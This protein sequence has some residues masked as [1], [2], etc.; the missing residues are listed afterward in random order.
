M[1]FHLIYQQLSNNAQTPIRVVEQATGR[2]VGWINRYLD[3]EYVRRL[4]ET[5]LRIY[6]YH[7][8][9]FV[10]WWESVHHTGDIREGDLTES[11]LLDYVRFQSS[12]QPRPSPSTINDRVAVAD[13]AIRNKF[14]EAPCQI[15][16]G[17]HHAFL[18]RK[19]M[20]LGRPRVVLSRLRVKVPKRN[21][22]PLSV[23]EVARFWSSFR[24][25]RDLAIV[26]LMLLQG[27]RS[28]EVLALNQDDALLSE[29]QLRV[30][31][32]GNKFR[33][34]PLAPETVQ[35]LEH[36]LRLER[37]NPCSAALFVSLKGRAR[38]TRMT[39]AGLRSLF[40]HHRQTTNV[41]LANPHRFRHTFASD[42]IRAGMSLPALM[43]LMGHSDIQTTLI[44]VTVTPQ[45]VYQQYARAVAQHIRPLPVTT[46]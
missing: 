12:Q 38:G 43:Q 14:P 37:P 23:N 41:Q 17:F 34:L 26:G 31:G 8:L 44:Y 25:S 45:D 6:A 4:A 10:R 15:A 7:L 22:V 28:A 40:R 21:I 33:F 11:T 32:K 5:S 24:T 20:G 9:H 27:L 46:S 42:M 30:R 16:H 35:L 1:K 18:R 36:Y 13:R 3:R 29:A 19:P 39:P 2:E